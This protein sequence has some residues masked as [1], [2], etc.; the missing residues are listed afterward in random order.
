MP[1]LLAVRTTRTGV[2]GTSIPA[3]AATRAWRLWQLLPDAPQWGVLTGR[4]WYRGIVSAYAIEQSQQIMSEIG[5][6][7]RAIATELS[8]RRWP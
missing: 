4:V 3:A 8:T 1:S 5:T 6:V 2:R 7:Q